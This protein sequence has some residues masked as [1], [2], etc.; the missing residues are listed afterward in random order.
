METIVQQVIPPPRSR[1]DTCHYG[2]HKPALSSAAIFLC[3][4]KQFKDE[5][6]TR[7]D[8]SYSGIEWLPGK[9]NVVT[10]SFKIVKISSKF[11]MLTPLHVKKMSLT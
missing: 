10:I 1:V 4:E 3:N 5:T 11:R 9:N 8:F 6:Q 2:K 7:R